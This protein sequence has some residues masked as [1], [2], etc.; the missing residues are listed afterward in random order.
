MG[1][2]NLLLSTGVVIT[3]SACLLYAWRAHWP[4]R[5]TLCDGMGWV[6]WLLATGLTAWAALAAYEIHGL[7]FPERCHHRCIH[8]RLGRDER[9][10]LFAFLVGDGVGADASAVME[11][12]ES[13]NGGG[14]S[15]RPIG[16]HLLW[17]SLNISASSPF[18]A[19]LT[20]PV[21][22]SLR[23]GQSEPRLR[24]VLLLRSTGFAAASTHD[25]SAANAVRTL[26]ALSAWAARHGVATA[27]AELVRV[28]QPKARECPILPICHT[29]FCLYI[30]DISYK[31]K[32]EG[33]P[34]FAHMSRPI[35]PM[36][37]RQHFSD[38]RRGSAPFFPYVTPHFPHI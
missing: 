20:V 26:D 37:H 28:V 11:A 6:A 30:T 3:W 4:T 9:V 14:G 13:I 12:E 25:A 15:S 18:D 29:P 2:D 10:D 17:T 8:P 7:Y 5:V 34:H 1:I 24:L 22:A 16:A 32:C 21:P 19:E 35:F 36:Y 33:V 31:T 38:R 23:R 27:H